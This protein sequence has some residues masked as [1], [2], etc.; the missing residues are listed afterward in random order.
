[1]EKAPVHVDEERLGGVARGEE[2]DA[3]LRPRGRV[4]GDDVALTRGHR[5]RRVAQALELPDPLT[6]LG[7]QVGVGRA[8]AGT[9]PQSRRE[10][11]PVGG[12]AWSLCRQCV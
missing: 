7:A 8:D 9:L 3:G 1:M 11:G 6:L 10:R 5:T 2:V 12:L 4:D